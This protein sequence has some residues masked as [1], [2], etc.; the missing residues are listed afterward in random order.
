MKYGYARVSPGGKNESVEAQTR[1]LTKA[2]CRKVFRDTVITTTLSMEA[3][4]AASTWESTTISC[5][6]TVSLKRIFFGF[7]LMIYL[8]FSLVWVASAMQP[9][10][11]PRAGCANGKR[12]RG[13]KPL[14][15]RR[16]VGP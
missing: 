10:P 2:G 14:V 7:L 4:D 12:L 5:A 1:Q 8:P 15:V 3:L 13:R 16:G 11:S 6:S 9:W